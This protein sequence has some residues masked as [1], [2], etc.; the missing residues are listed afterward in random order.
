[1]PRRL[2]EST[3]S[4]LTS[5]EVTRLTNKP[6]RL[7]KPRRTLSTKSSSLSL[8]TLASALSRTKSLKRSGD[9][10]RPSSSFSMVDGESIEST[11][12]TGDNSELTSVALS[13]QLTHV[14]SGGS[15]N[16]SPPTDNNSDKAQEFS[17]KLQTIVNEARKSYSEEERRASPFRP[18]SA[19]SLKVKGTASSS[20]T[21]TPLKKRARSFTA[22]SGSAQEREHT[23]L[24]N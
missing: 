20:K 12:S 9:T 4:A 22:P 5:P 24:L 7:H 16:A 8:H 19:R 18:A 1:M 21:E 3:S 11:T 2:S 13:S 10:S 14:S 17:E 23:R 6:S 15:S